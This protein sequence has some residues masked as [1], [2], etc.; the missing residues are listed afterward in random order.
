MVKN[1]SADIRDKVSIPGWGR[2]PEECMQPT[3]VLSPGESH[4]QKS[5]VGCSPQGRKELD[6]DEAT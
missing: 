4:G 3:P 6:T 5:L 2:S 1:L